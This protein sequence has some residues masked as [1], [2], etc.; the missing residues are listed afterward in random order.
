M[1]ENLLFISFIFS[2]F[3]VYLKL[4]VRLLPDCLK[5]LIHWLLVFSVSGSKKSLIHI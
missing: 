3:Q 5:P 4:I 1:E 2:C